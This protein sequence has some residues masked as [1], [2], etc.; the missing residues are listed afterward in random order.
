MH[1]VK[2]V[3]Q[4]V[5]MV[6][7]M[8]TR[9]RPLTETCPKP[10]LPVLDKPCLSYLIENIAFAGID[11]I[12][13]ACGYRYPQL[14]ETIGD[15]SDIGVKIS[16]SFEDEPLG[17]AGAI[18]KVEEM[19]EDTFVAI[20]GDV[21]SRID[22]AEI[23]KEHFSSDAAITIS[24]TE[25]KNPC[26]YGIARLEKDGR[27]S[28]FKEKPKPEEVFSNLINAGYYVVQKEVLKYVPDKRQYDFSKELVMDLMK[29]EC[30]IQGYRYTGPWLDVGR[31]SDLIGANLMAAESFSE[32]SKMP[33]KKMQDSTLDRPFYLGENSSIEDSISRSSVIHKNCIIRNSDLTGSLIMRDCT[34]VSST[35]VNSIL[36][37][38]CRISQGSVIE[39][40]VLGDGTVVPENT[41]IVKN[42]VTE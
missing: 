23:I 19:L 38:G 2:K 13:L 10:I 7:G 20:N 42:E 36:G 12:I 18:K 11:E 22:V 33:S 15:G 35:L 41:K 31:P 39:D 6:G 29:K 26:E 30:R 16:Y 8:G 21:F 17:T 27:I 4:A 28:E 9:L 14:A 1:M 25:V 5:I 34:V 40:S 37:K 3:N 24:L 32:F